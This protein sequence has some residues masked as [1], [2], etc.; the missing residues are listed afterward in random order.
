MRIK[1]RKREQW[2][3]METYEPSVFEKVSIFVVLDLI[4]FCIYICVYSEYVPE[5]GQS[6]RKPF[7]RT[8][9][10]AFVLDVKR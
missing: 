10:R 5:I 2:V 6:H 4:Y 9:E 7:R 8:R 3:Y 1:E